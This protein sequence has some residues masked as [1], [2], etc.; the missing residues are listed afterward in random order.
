MA[1]WHR[2]RRPPQPAYCAGGAA[3]Y[4]FQACLQLQLSALMS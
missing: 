1:Q 3:S 2:D 4:R